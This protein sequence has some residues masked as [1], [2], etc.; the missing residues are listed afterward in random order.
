MP[1]AFK[2]RVYTPDRDDADI[3]KKVDE[4]LYYA[5]S[6]KKGEFIEYERLINSCAEE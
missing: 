5:K 6:N 4:A 3:F 2:R 1:F